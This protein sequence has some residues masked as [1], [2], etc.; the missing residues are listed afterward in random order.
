MLAAKWDGKL[1]EN[2]YGG[3]APLPMMEVLKTKK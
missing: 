1:P 3:N 2:Y